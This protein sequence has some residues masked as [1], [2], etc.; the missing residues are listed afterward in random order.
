[1]SFTNR[2]IKKFNLPDGVQSIVV[3]DESDQEYS[4]EDHE[5]KSENPNK[6]EPEDDPRPDKDMDINEYMGANTSTPYVEITTEPDVQAGAEE[7]IQSAQE[8]TSVSATPTVPI[9][10]AGLGNSILNAPKVVQVSTIQSDDQKEALQKQQAALYAQMASYQGTDDDEGDSFDPQEDFENPINQELQFGKDTE[11]FLQKQRSG[12]VEPEEEMEFM[13]KQSA[14]HRKKRELAALLEEAEES[15]LFVPERPSHKSARKGRKRTISE[16][17]SDSD[18]STMHSSRSSSKKAKTAKSKSRKNSRRPLASKLSNSTSLNLGGHNNFWES[19]DAAGQMNAEPTVE[20]AALRADALK[21]IRS[22]AEMSKEAKKAI[23]LDAKR[24]DRAVQSFVGKKGTS[25]GHK[26][27]TAVDGGWFV[28]GMITPLKNYQLINCGWMR[29]RENGTDE[30]KGGIVADQMGL[31]KTVTCLANIVNGRPLKSYHAFLRRDSHTTLIIVP[32]SLL[33]QW[34]SEIGKHTKKE[35]KRNNF[36]LGKS[37][38]F[39][40]SMSKDWRFENFAGFD[41]ILTT[42]YDV[43][44]SWPDCKYPEGL[45]EQQRNDFWLENFYNKRGPLHR[46]KFLRVVLDEGHQIAN[47]ET[48]VSK[49]CYNLIAD[50]KWILTGTP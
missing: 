1:M 10:P 30:P 6:T 31:G 5:P 40:D 39:K 47:P 2:K 14:Y 21:G 29:S 17:A 27:L 23:A 7:E 22:R 8:S 32:S 45:S 11:V 4:N 50:H 28:K 16:V 25:R 37:M 42:Y 49:A 24:L 13:K 33:G 20:G 9:T 12:K 34:Q 3:E 43:R 44:R 48:Q 26:S 38:V 19:I 15:L 36:G 35:I 18:N 46:Y 41:V